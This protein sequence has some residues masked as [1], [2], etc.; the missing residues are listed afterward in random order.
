M[1][2]RNIALAAQIAHEANRAW[3]QAIGDNSQLPWELAPEW[4][5]TSAMN[6]VR[7]V[8]A[9]NTPEQSHESWLAE[10]AATGWKYGPVKNPE[11]KEHPCFVPYAELPPEQ[12]AKDHLYVG[13]VKV[14]LE[15]TR[16]A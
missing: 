4:Q 1:E 10:K 8:A 16:E 7:G 12:K 2:A 11:T 15:A 14:A 5:R 13:V 3:C 9:G 6:G